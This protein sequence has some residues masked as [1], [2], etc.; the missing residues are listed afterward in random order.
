M[1]FVRNCAA[2]YSKFKQFQDM[3]VAFL[4][5]ILIK[6]ME[7][8]P[9]FYVCYK[10]LSNYQKYIFVKYETNLVTILC[11]LLKYL[12]SGTSDFQ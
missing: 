11:L 9:N 2:R 6:R 1:T 12:F 8:Y 7:R 3:G 4:T 10:L 5:C